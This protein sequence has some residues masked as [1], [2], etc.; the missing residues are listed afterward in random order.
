VSDSP[1]N[2]PSDVPPQSDAP[3]SRPMT[4]PPSE[5]RPSRGSFAT[6]EA[7]LD[8]RPVRVQMVVALVLGLV[9]VAIPLY[10]WRRPR[11]EVA[12]VSLRTPDGGPAESAVDE[13]PPEPPSRVTVSAPQ[14]L[15][16]QDP[17][18]GKTPP[19]KCDHLEPVEAALTKA[20]EESAD[21]VPEAQAGT[22]VFVADVSFKRK[23]I[24]VLVPRDG[25]SIKTS[26]VYMGCQQ[27]VKAKMAQVPVAGLTHAHA[28]YKIKVVATYAKKGGG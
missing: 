5:P 22:I 16:C 15:A 21:C 11:A 12:A 7:Q 20:V 13:P 10:L 17:G 24:G 19:E 18:P 1:T 4:I 9:L 3:S 25:R 27:A 14:T 6:I 28:R 23:A 26:S 8:D 2:T